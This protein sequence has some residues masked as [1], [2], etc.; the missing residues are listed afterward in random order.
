MPG[1]KQQL[2]CLSKRKILIHHLHPTADHWHFDAQELIAF[3]IFHHSSLEEAHEYVSLTVIAQGDQ[4]VG[5]LL[6]V[7]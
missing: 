2:L 5:D 3:T 1:R 6:C 7:C 4:T